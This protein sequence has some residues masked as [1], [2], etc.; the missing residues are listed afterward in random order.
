L[1]QSFGQAA[2]RFKGRNGH[3]AGVKDIITLGPGPDPRLGE[4]AIDLPKT[5]SLQQP[6]TE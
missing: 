5:C 6:A 1:R 4:P 2:G 3:G